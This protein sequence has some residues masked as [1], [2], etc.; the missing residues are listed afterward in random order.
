MAASA[1]SE[2][3]RRIWLRA[4]GVVL[5]LALAFPVL[6]EVAPVPAA[7]RA[8]AA[9]DYAKAARLWEEACDAG[10]AGGCYELAIVYRDGE[11]VPADHARFLELAA[12]ACDGGDGRGCY[13]VAKDE[14]RADEEGTATATPEQLE[15]GM[16]FYRKGCDLGFAPACRNLALHVRDSQPAD[17]DPEATIAGFDRACSAGDGAACFALAGLFD[18][19]EGVPLRDDP[20]AAND[21]LRRGCNQLDNDSCQNLAWH[22]AH[23]FGLETDFV[24]SAALYQLAC[25]DAA[26]F[27]CFMIPS[28]HYAAPPYEGSEIRSEWSEAAGAYDRACKADFAP[29]CFGLARLIA[30]G[31]QGRKHEPQIRALLEKAIELEPDY[32]VATEL[33]RRVDAGELPTD[34][35][36]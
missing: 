1:L 12:N 11:G 7:D 33:L 19:H 8:Y 20:A 13:G 4:V 15:R 21:A 22:Y 30:R 27:N 26:G 3:G 24:R 14:L 6:A 36:L 9:R 23:G 25:G 10:N 29:G 5:L 32:P 31:G 28:A 34:A 16:A 2:T 17:A 35:I 18:L